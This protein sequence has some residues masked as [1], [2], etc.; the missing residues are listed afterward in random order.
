M[1]SLFFTATP[2][3]VVS[4]K[5]DEKTAWIKVPSPYSGPDKFVDLKE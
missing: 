3:M 5:Y 4:D 2:K 1:F